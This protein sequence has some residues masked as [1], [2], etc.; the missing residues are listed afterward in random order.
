MNPKLIALSGGAA[1]FAA[2]CS[3]PAGGGAGGL[4]PLPSG[5][6]LTAPATQA[7]PTYA[8]ARKLSDQVKVGMAQRS[9]EAMFGPPDKAGYRLYGQ[10]AGTPWRALV[11][12]WTF[13]DV[14]PPRVLSVVFQEVE[15][16][17]RVNHGDWP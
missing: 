12:E 7:K 11:W 17:W 16:S 3:E 2:A 14:T 15:G 10:A 5:P 8:S 1:L 9:V 13:Q 6:P 4:P